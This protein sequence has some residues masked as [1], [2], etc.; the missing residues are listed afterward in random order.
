METK[1]RRGSR[2]FGRLAIFNLSDRVRLFLS[3]NMIEITEYVVKILFKRVL[4]Y[5]S[6]KVV[7]DRL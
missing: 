1:L 3:R 4:I 7:K 6:T 5:I 2:L